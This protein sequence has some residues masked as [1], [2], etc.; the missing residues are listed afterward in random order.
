MRLGNVSKA[1]RPPLAIVPR[2]PAA[3]A[4]LGLV[5]LGIVFSTSDASADPSSQSV[6]VQGG[7]AAAE[8]VFRED[9]GQDMI[10]VEN[11]VCRITF[12]SEHGGL[13]A[14]TNRI[15]GDPCLKQAKCGT[16]PFRVYADLTKE[17]DIAIN[18]KFQLVFDDPEAITRTLVQPG[19][20]RLSKVDHEGPLNL[21]YEGQGF[22]ILLG[23]RLSTGA[24]THRDQ[25]GVSDWSLRITNTGT[26]SREFLVC[27]PYL[28]GVRLGPDSSA[29]L[30]TAM[31]QAGIV[32]PAWERPGGVLGESNQLSMQWHAVWDPATRNAFALIFMD[33]DVRPKRLLLREPTIA[34][35]H[36]PPVKLPPGG[37][38]DLPPVRMIVYQGDWRPAARA[39]RAWYDQAYPHVEPPAWF[40]RSNGNT[41]IHFKKAGPGVKSGYTGQVVLDSFR[42][43]P[44]A[45]IRAPIDN[46]EYAFYC[47][48][49]MRL[50]DRPY[51]P[52]TDGENIVREDMGG[53]EAMREGIAGVHRLG[54][55]AT[56]YIDGYIMHE[57]SDIAKS[58]KGKQWA[59]MRKDG[60]ITG[61]Y[62]RQG[63]YPMCAGCVEWQDHL[64]GMV[65][66]LLRE[67]GA[68]AIRLDSL[69]FYYL[70]CYNPAHSHETPF[71]YNEWLKQLLAKVRKAAIG[72]NPDVLLLTEGSADW[73]G[74]WFHGA[75]T[76][77][78]PR[79]LSMMRLAVGPFRPYVYASGAL[80]GSLSGFPGGDCAG[81][82]VHTMDWNWLCA[83][84]PAHEALV[85]GDVADEDPQS[86]DPQIV[87]RRFAGDGY[88]A[89]VA[90][91]PA[92]Q[93]PI[94][95]RG[96]GVS[97]HRAGYVLTVPGLAAQV[98]DAVLC[99]VETLTWA[100]LETR[101]AGD[102][103]QVRLNTNWALVILRKV[104]GPA[105]VSF[106]PL[107][108]LPKGNSTIIRLQLLR[109]SPG[110]QVRINAPGLE[111]EPSEITVP[112]EITVTVPLDAFPG[113]YAVSISGDRVLGAKR[114][115]I[116]E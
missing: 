103:L 28:D 98:A 72:V 99:D 36:F 76:S 34:L 5:S 114:F 37:S 50:E 70:P 74:Q 82:D 97:D 69:G 47:R 40:R 1:A 43:L 67:T 17:F 21:H 81:L 24:R 111:V 41:G 32:V 8:V 61:P 91:R 2:T 18:E 11:S 56:L 63:F 55:H 85:W 89:V 101:R 107:P 42:E 88:W 68:D 38:A 45:H 49:S 26:D 66:R 51:Y 102:D 48:T 54:L 79:D 71:G 87:A 90:A 52:H 39:Y 60:T 77:R 116:V 93:D 115:L 19:A 104:D 94:W 46:W 44:A 53:A 95:P 6:E 112:G 110:C 22:R 73:V 14:I 92:C 86:S 58:G 10:T 100:P 13:R 30:A 113:N 3:Y 62:S 106:D 83:R 64:A 16:M 75:L 31:D 65:A 96:T 108:S 35:H 9:A 15:S 105:I 27:F 25:G 23:V 33:P 57:E 29:N 20:C 59:V 109:G 7:E 4:V 78:C 12:D 84:F 80:W